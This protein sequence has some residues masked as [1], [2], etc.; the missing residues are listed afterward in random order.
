MI[1]TNKPL[2][3]IPISLTSLPKLGSNSTNHF[4]TNAKHIIVSTSEVTKIYSREISHNTYHIHTETGRKTTP[5]HNNNDIRISKWLKK[6]R[7]GDKRTSALL[8]LRCTTCVSLYI[9]SLLPHSSHHFLIL[10]TSSYFKLVYL[11]NTE[12]RL[13]PLYIYIYICIYISKMNCLEPDLTQ[14]LYFR[15]H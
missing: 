15:L 14:A 11:T 3:W 7:T 13:C 4:L 2:H 6:Y 8:L 9:L 12:V 10:H 1:A 5:Y